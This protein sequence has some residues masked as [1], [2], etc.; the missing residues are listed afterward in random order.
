VS[1]RSDKHWCASV[2]YA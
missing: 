1:L 2:W